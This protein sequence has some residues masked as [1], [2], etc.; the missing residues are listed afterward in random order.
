MYTSFS[1]CSVCSKGKTSTTTPEGVP[2]AKGRAPLFSPRDSPL[3]TIQ[4]RVLIYGIRMQASLRRP[5]ESPETNLRLR[6]RLRR[7]QP[8]VRSC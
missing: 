5:D 2:R 8:H 6:W 4:R 1:G 3:A 7:T